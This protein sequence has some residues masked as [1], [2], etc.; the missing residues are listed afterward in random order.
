MT[1]SYYAAR[2]NLYHL[3]QQ[4]PDWDHATLAAAVG[5][6]KGW[7]KKWLKRF[8]EEG[9]AGIPLADILPGHSRAR[10]HPPIKTHPLV[11]EQVLAI[12][13]QPPEG[14][15][16]VPGQEAIHYYLE[17]DPALQFFQLPLPS[18]KT[19]YRILK[20]HDRILSRGKHVHQPLPRPAPMTCWQLDFKDVSSVP[21]DPLGKRQHVVE[22]LNIIDT[23]TSVLLDAH[24]R[25]DFTAETALEALALT[26]A[27]YGCPKLI[28][29]DR[30]TR[31]VGSPAGSDFP[32]ALIRFCACLDIAVQV[33]APQHPQEN[34]FVERYNRTYQ[35]ECLALD[36]PHDLSQARTAT[37]AFV[38]HYNVERPHQGL[39]CGNRP[40]RSAF[41][42]LPALPPLPSTIDPD[43]WLD[44]LDGLH[45]ERK[46]DRHGMLSIDLKRYYVSSKLVGHH[47]SVQLD[48]Q[49]RCLHVYLEQQPIKSLP[50]RG[51]LGHSLS[52]EQFLTHMLQ[53]A[54]AQHR[55]RSLQER[56]YRTATFTSP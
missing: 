55:L 52:F 56:R 12:R 33:C 11:V 7:V 49:A 40:P 8:R 36:Q 1:I 4:H 16:R 2:T 27:K 10:K 45:V 21:A 37:E 17:R 22:T 35:E 5:C 44:E 28:T 31:W 14:L 29:L 54:R 13:D 26:P 51:L 50:V 9:A 18:G 19:I 32:A 39:A 6:S 25:A 43:S 42:T 38:Q 41:P 20:A 53:Q 30:D 47:V 24:V 48:A 23:G 3:W 15:R 34:G 46:I